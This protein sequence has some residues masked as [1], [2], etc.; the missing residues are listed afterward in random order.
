MSK[1]YFKILWASNLFW[2]TWEWKT[3]S[4]NAIR[5]AI[6]QLAA[7]NLHI[8]HK[9]CTVA[10]VAEVCY[11]V[12]S[13]FGCV[14][15]PR[16]VFTLHELE[17][18][19]ETFVKVQRIIRDTGSFLDA[20]AEREWR[21]GKQYSGSGAAKPSVQAEFARCLYTATVLA[22]NMSPENNEHFCPCPFSTE[23]ILCFIRHLKW[24]RIINYY[25]QIHAV[26]RDYAT[27]KSQTKK[28]Q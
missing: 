15:N 19:S 17:F 23:N 26:P 11:S 20:K 27:Y 5:P 1:T 6:V 22:T 9:E 24:P 12:T 8:T 3:N 13:V 25:A 18:R 4:I 14:S 21:W 28:S 7:T 16:S 10:T 2:K